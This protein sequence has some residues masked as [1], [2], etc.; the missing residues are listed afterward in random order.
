MNAGASAGSYLSPDTIEGAVT[1]DAERLI[2]LVNRD[3]GVILIDSRLRTDRNMSFI[4]GSVSLPDT[5]TDCKSLARIIPGK[6]SN[7][8]FYCNGPRCRRSDRAVM[9]AMKCGYSNVHWFR[10]GMASWRA[11]TYPIDQ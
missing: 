7:V 3:A 1:I 11:A 5:L 4:P 10:G 6:S 2:E 8:V 9:T